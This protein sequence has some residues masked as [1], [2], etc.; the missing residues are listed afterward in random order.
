MI[1]RMQSFFVF[2]VTAMYKYILIEEWDKKTEIKKEVLLSDKNCNQ[3]T[4]CSQIAAVSL[5]M[6]KISSN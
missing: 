4:R 5:K 1:L 3:I 2:Y 6:L